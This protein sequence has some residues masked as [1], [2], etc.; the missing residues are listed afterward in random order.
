VTAEAASRRLFFALWP[1]EALR[2]AIEQ[3][4]GAG[5]MRAGG[6]KIPAENFH[7]TLIFLG[8]VPDHRLHEV[9]DAASAVVAPPFELKLDRLESWR[10]SGVLCLTAQSPS[11]LASLR[12]QL[13]ASLAERQ[14]QLEEGPFQPHVTLVRRWAH[15]AP[16]VAIEPIRWAIDEFVLVQSQ[17][18]PHGSQYEVLHRWPLTGAPGEVR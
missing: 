7:I 2:R 18:G 10:R 1:S 15:S 3:A 14:F 4:T 17:A 6:R 5:A 12:I 16:P 13:R 9:V 11:Q 8:S